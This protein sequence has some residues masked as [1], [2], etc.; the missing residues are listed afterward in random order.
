MAMGLPGTVADMRGGTHWG[1]DYETRLSCRARPEALWK[2]VADV[3]QWPEFTE[4][5]N[6]VRL[7][8]TPLQL[9]SQASIKQPRTRTSQWTVT[10][11]VPGRSFTWESSAAGVLTVA[12]HE[13]IDTA[14]HT[15]LVVRFRQRG[16]LAG[17]LGMLFGR[18]IRRFVDME[19]NGLVA[20]AEASDHRQP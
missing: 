20:T 7:D 2:V 15:Q 19:A 1:V 6:S 17:V 10:E 9:G 3:E 14:G 13:V 4:S 12:D 11:L 8:K 18:R 16:A 5:M